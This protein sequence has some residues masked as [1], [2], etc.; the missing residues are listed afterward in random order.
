[1][2]Y[3]MRSGWK[4][5]DLVTSEGVY[6]ATKPFQSYWN[7]AVIFEFNKEDPPMNTPELKYDNYVKLYR[8]FHTN[9]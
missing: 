3:W 6:G 8:E 7:D 4:L 2:S 5:A 1:M 9:N